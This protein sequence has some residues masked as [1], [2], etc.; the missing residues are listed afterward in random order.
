MQPTF[1]SLSLVNIWT[2]FHFKSIFF[3]V[4]AFF[5]RAVIWYNVLD[6]VLHLATISPLEA[7]IYVVD[8]QFKN[9]KHSNKHSNFY[10]LPIKFKNILRD[11]MV[12]LS[13]LNFLYGFHFGSLDCWQFKPPL[14]EAY[15]SVN[16]FLALLQTTV[17]KT[18]EWEYQAHY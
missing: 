8:I 18:T 5:D 16:K 7:I 2:S 6:V 15:L 13:S 11:S 10:I 12:I 3:V 17:S 14:F 9:F 1:I 4:A